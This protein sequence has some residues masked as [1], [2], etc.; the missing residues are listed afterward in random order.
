VWKVDVLIHE[1]Q[2]DFEDVDDYGEPIRGHAPHCPMELTVN[3]KVDAPTKWNMT[4]FIEGEL[5]RRYPTISIYEMDF[6]ILVI[7]ASPT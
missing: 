6:D 5:Y 2:Y 7:R 3:A 4:G 1:V